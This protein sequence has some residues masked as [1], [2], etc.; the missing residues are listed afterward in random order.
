M[1]GEFDLVR[2]QSKNLRKKN[3]KGMP[4]YVYTQHL[5]LFPLSQNRELLPFLNKDLLFS[6]TINEG[7]LNITLKIDGQEEKPP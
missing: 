1:L 3:K 2:I 4:P 5:L 6:K 7:T